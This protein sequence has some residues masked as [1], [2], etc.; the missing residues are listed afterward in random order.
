MLSIIV[1]QLRN[2]PIFNPSSQY[3]ICLQSHWPRPLSLGLMNHV[4]RTRR[5][6]KQKI[7]H[8]LG[9][10]I[11]YSGLTALKQF[12]EAESM[13][14][15][16]WIPNHWGGFNLLPY[17]SWA[18]NPKITHPKGKAR[19]FTNK[20]C[21]LQA[22]MLRILGKQLEHMTKGS[23]KEKENNFT[24]TTELQSFTCQSNGVVPPEPSSPLHL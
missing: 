9:F 7:R 5:N 12:H 4:T 2:S 22:T 23:K 15:C 3:T 8:C 17:C 24:I 13:P 21:N 6:K 20:S 16:P 19:S 10:L 11:N 18:F 1:V 14:R